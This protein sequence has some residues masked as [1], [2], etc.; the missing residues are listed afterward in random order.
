VW[1]VPVVVALL[2]LPGAVR[3]GAD[4]ND[5]GIAWVPYQDALASAKESGKPVCLVFYT[6]WCPHCTAFSRVFHDGEVVE[7]SKAF[8]MVRLNRDKHRELSA[9]YAPDG[10]YIP[11]TYFLS[12]DG[13]L[14]ASLHAPRDKYKYFYDENDPASLLAGMDRALSKLK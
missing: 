12:T 6:E 2:L 5:A 13:Q 11:R 10:Q 7:K 3:A 9:Q 8:V 4:W 1:A 14:D